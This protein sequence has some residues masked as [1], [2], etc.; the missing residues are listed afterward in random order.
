MLG[1]K[2]IMY[3]LTKLILQGILSKSKEYGWPVVAFDG[4]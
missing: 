2:N 1:N 4:D 3:M